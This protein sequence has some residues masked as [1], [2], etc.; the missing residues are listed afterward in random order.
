MN[1]TIQQVL[2]LVRLNVK[3]IAR[4][5]L[6]ILLP[7]IMAI[8]LG[9]ACR[10]SKAGLPSGVMLVG[11]V[12]GVTI[13]RQLWIDRATHFFDCIQSAGAGARTQ[14]IAAF[15]IWIITTM[16]LSSLVF[17]LARL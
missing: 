13:M 17:I 6:L 8:I 1:T 12:S 2:C 15:V 10:F 11:V 4:E 7:V 3:R 16:S 9:L 14:T 5:H